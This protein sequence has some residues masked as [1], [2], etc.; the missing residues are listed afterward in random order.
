MFRNV[1]SSIFV[2]LVVCAG[3]TRHAAAQT[4]INFSPLAQAGGDATGVP[5]SAFHGVGSSYTQDGFTFT[6][7]DNPWGPQTLG[8][9]KRRSSNHPPG[10][11]KAT[12]LTAYY[13]ATRITIT[14]TTASFDLTSIDLAQWGAGQ[15]GGRGTFPVTFHGIRGEREVATQTFQ[16]HRMPRS[17]VLSTYRFKGFTNLTSVYV[18]EEGTFATGYGFQLNNMVVRSSRTP[19]PE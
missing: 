19:N 6:A 17:P 16:V 15:G 7:T 14:T 13:A 9:W 3:F 2:V 12:S 5:L 10:G 8:A 4:T 1:L 18:I 11:N